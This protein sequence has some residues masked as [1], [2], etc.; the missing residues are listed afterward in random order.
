MT[1]YELRRAATAA[2]QREA[3]RHAQYL[4]DQHRRREEQLHAQ[5]RERMAALQQAL[6][7]TF[8]AAIEHELGGRHMLVGDDILMDA[9]YE[10][11]VGDVV[12]RLR[13]VR[14]EVHEPW[15]CEAVVGGTRVPIKTVPDRAD[16]NRDRLLLALHA[17]YGGSDVST[18]RMQRAVGGA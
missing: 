9:V 3:D 6:H 14:D 2:A 7:T 10:V 8:G 18:E 1:E 13:H 15:V 16:V 11:A 4:A 12:L 17:V 5:R